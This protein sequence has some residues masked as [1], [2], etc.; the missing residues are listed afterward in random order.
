M[1]DFSSRLENLIPV[2]PFAGTLEAFE[3]GVKLRTR[4]EY[5]RQQ[6]LDHNQTIFWASDSKRVEETAR[7]FAAGFYGID[8]E[9]VATLHVVPETSDL[10]GDTLTPG[11]TCKNYRDTTN[12]EGHDKG[13]RK[14]DE[15]KSTYLPAIAERL[16]EQDP[17]INFSETDVLTMQEMCGFELLAKGDS[18][19]CDVFSYEEWM[20]FEYARDIL[21]FYRA[22][23]G[24]RYAPTMGTL[25]LNATKNLLIQGPEAGP[26]FFSL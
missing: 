8:W 5:L 7:Y 23:A 25:F 17:E 3:T 10:G 6:A 19:W 9:D 26:L 20:N 12:E 16:H 18:P 2:G 1:P 11:V 21:H 15:F 22:G 24:N 4:Y 13:Y 14:L